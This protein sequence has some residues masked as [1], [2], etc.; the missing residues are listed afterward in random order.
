MRN[1]CR[2]TSRSQCN[3]CSLVSKL[4]IHVHRKRSSMDEESTPAGKNMQARTNPIR[5]NRLANLLIEASPVAIILTD[6]SATISVVN[7]M[8]EVWFGY[9]ESELIGKNLRIL[10]SAKSNRDDASQQACFLSQLHDP[11]DGRQWDLIGCRND[12]TEFPVRVLLHPLV[13]ASGD[14]ILANVIAERKT[15]TLDQERIAGERLAAVL[16]MVSGLAHESRNALQR[17]QSCL[18]LLDLDLSDNSEL[19][20]LTGSIRTALTDLRN[21]YEE[22]KDYAAPIVLKRSKVDL[23]QLCQKT[24]E[25]IAEQYPQLSPRLSIRCDLSCGRIC[26]DTARMGQVFQQLFEN[27]IQASSAQGEIVVA[28]R[29]M[30]T[31]PSRSIEITVRDHGSGLSDA[32]ASRLFEPFFTTKQQGTGLGLAVCQRIVEAH[33]GT[34]TAV[35]HCDGGVAVRIVLPS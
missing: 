1:A 35:N 4:L 24:F 5:Q 19:L 10:F 12:G 33:R 25:E 26:V 28:C 2:E 18:D 9:R 21:N 14:M 27:A 3:L 30:D 6:S 22:V 11:D 15:E 23:S 34:I 32:A 13:T 17:A 29:S 7:H 8:T 16:E 31:T 20:Q